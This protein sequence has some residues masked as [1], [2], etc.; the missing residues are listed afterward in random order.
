[1]CLQ[2]V[3]D[4]LLVDVMHFYSFNFDFGSIVSPRS[5]ITFHISEMDQQLLS[6]K[7]HFI[8]KG[9]EATEMV[10]GDVEGWN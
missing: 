9:N 2:C 1:M 3:L 10:R 7:G 4:C 5:H 6:Y 8:L